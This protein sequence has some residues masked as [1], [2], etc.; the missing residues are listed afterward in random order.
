MNLLRTA[1]LPVELI[2]PN[3]FLARQVYSPESVACT[4]FKEKINLYKVKNG[5]NSNVY[6]VKV[7]KEVLLMK[8]QNLLE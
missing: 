2:P 5:A 7:C 1:S 6:E 3:L 4:P 8:W